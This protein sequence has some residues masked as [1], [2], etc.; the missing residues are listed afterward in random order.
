[1]E[2][3]RRLAAYFSVPWHRDFY[4]TC[5][6]LVGVLVLWACALR[7]RI[8]RRKPFLQIVAI[9]MWLPWMGSLAARL[10]I[11]YWMPRSL[12][13][14]ELELLL[15]VATLVWF[16]PM[17][18]VMIAAAV[19]GRA[20]RRRQKTGRMRNDETLSEESDADTWPR[21]QTPTE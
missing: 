9:L 14:V 17:V 2:E 20:E 10:Y 1:M 13:W 16:I 11:Y 21:R 8:H 6:L 15:T 3:M 4:G 7:R 18:G 5:A 19:Q 12:H